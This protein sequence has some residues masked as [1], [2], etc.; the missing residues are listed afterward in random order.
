MEVKT[1]Q[2][3]AKQRKLKN[4][5]ERKREESS[6]ARKLAQKLESYGRYVEIFSE[7]T[8]LVIP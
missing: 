3:T 5:T 8:V 7:F 2:R 1:Y 6:S 4:G